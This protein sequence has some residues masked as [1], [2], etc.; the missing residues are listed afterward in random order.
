[1]CRLRYRNAVTYLSPG[2]AVSLPKGL[3]RG[4]ETNEC[5]TLKALNKLAVLPA[6]YNFVRLSLSK[7]ATSYV[8]EVLLDENTESISLASSTSG[9]H[10]GG[11]SDHH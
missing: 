11:D 2:L 3:L 5:I 10:S 8:P 4:N 7:P 1:V 9:R 6:G